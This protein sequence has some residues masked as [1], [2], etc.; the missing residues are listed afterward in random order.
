MDGKAKSSEAKQA[1]PNK[2]SQAE[3]LK[4]AMAAVEPKGKYFHW[5]NVQKN[6]KLGIFEKIN[7]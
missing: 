6:K 7:K 4:S 1:Q 3:Q 5:D 2:P